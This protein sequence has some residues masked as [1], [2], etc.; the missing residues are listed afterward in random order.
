MLTNLWR[1]FSRV[2]RSRSLGT[3]PANTRWS[4]HP[5]PSEGTTVVHCLWYACTRTSDFVYHTRMWHAQPIRRRARRRTQRLVVRATCPLSISLIGAY[6][7]WFWLRFCHVTNLVRYRSFVS[8][9][10]LFLGGGRNQ[11]PLECERLL[12]FLLTKAHSYTDSQ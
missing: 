5:A 11:I 1:R 12:Y 7:V 3:E 9:F 10:L 6:V 2:K 4:R 8:F